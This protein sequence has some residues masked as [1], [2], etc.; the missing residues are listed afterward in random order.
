MNTTGCQNTGGPVFGNRQ[1]VCLMKTTLYVLQNYDDS[2]P[3][4]RHDIDVVHIG[5]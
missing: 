5:G 2:H 1:P 3:D 4:G